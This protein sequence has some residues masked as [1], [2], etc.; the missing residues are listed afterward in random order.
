[1]NKEL[2]KNKMK[3]TMGGKEAPKDP[4]SPGSNPPVH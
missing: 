4:P 3:M 2:N 1:M